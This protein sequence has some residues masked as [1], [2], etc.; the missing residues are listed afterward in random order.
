M[1]M[2]T[3]LLLSLYVGFV[4]ASLA[5]FLYG[6]SG[7]SAYSELQHDAFRLEGNLEELTTIHQELAAEFEALRRSE[8][9]IA[10]RAR[11]LGYLRENETILKIYGVDTP[12]ENYAVGRIVVPGARQRGRSGFSL[13]AGLVAMLFCFLLI[14]AL[15]PRMPHES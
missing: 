13:N 15:A 12:P 6:P 9:T 10:L 11:D 14:A 2:G 3:R 1:K 7:L 5:Y 8:D 4:V